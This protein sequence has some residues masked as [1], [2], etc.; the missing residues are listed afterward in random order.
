MPTHPRIYAGVSVV[1]WGK[2]RK[3]DPAFFAE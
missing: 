1:T 2:T 3:L